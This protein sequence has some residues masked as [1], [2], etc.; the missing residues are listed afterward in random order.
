MGIFGST[1]FFVLV[2]M[3]LFM[4]S[5]LNAGSMDVNQVRVEAAERELA[6]M[7]DLF[8][9]IVS[10]CRSKCFPPYYHEEELTKGEQCC[11]D[12]CVSKYMQTNLI[13]NEQFQLK[14]DP[15]KHT[16]LSQVLPTM[17]QHRIA[18]VSESK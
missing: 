12:R 8:G 6:A 3:S 15:T 1:N 5:M 10:S 11:I 17:G 9:N 18:E 14:A 13:V 4:G 7:M 16:S 2:S